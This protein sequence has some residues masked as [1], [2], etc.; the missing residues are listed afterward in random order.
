MSMLTDIKTELGIS[1]TKK[2]A[3]IQTAIKAA[4][5]RMRMI[6]VKVVDET[7]ALT[8][9]AIKLYAKG[10]YNYQGE[11]ERY[12]EAFEDL[13]NAMALSGDYNGGGCHE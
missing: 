4:K 6:G 10:K 2:E 13:A 1:H 12:T 8:S 7:D 9:E 11:G 5:Q 3:E